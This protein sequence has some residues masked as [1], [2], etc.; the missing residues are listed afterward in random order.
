V[1]QRPQ[2]LEGWVRIAISLGL[3]KRRADADNMVKACLDLLVEHGLIEDD[4]KIA[5]VSVAWSSEVPA[6][7][8]RIA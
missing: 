6:G 4:S 2:R 5:S 8:V 7:R 1:S 3:T